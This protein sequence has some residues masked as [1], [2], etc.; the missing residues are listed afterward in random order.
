MNMPGFTA[1]T[2]LYKTNVQYNAANQREH[3]SG[4]VHLAQ[5]DIF[6]PLLH[7]PVVPLCK[8]RYRCFVHPTQGVICVPLC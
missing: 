4:I 1:E 5:F 7:S 3:A 2:S 8:Y 6:T